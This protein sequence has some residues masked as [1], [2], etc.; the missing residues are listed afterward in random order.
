M[1]YEV[2]KIHSYAK[3]SILLFFLQLFLITRVFV[4]F[5]EEVRWAIKEKIS[6]KKLAP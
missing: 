5:E 3:A 4:R 1:P 6:T 2:R